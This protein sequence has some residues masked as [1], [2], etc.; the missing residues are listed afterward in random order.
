MINT[1]DNRLKKDQ[2][3]DT[4]TDYDYDKAGNLTLDAENRRFVFDAENRMKEFFHSSNASNTPD[5]TY[6][7]DGDGR[8]VKKVTGNRTV[9]FVY[10][11]S[12]QLVAEYDS[13]LATNPQV[14][15]LTADHLGSP[16]VITD[17]RGAIVS[18]HDY[19]AFGSD[20]TETIG[21]VGG[22]TTTLD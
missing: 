20:I 10:N 11:S 13:Q 7:Y 1:G 14:N 8:R 9:I 3:G 12:G 18:R 4:V 2:D 22:R 15:Y 6:H 19:M 17:G 5:A 21:N 16:R